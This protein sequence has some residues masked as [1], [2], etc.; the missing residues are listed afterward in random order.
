MSV[1]D[2]IKQKA[3][4]LDFSECGFARAEKVDDRAIERYEQWL[5]TGHNGCMAWA[6]RNIDVRNDPRLLLDGAKTVIMVALNYYPRRFQSPDAAQIAYYAYGRDYHDVI[7]RRLRELAAWISQ[8]TGEKCRALVDSAPLRERYWA[9]KAGLGFIGLNNQLIIPGKG[10][11]FFLGALLTTLELEPDEPCRDSCRQCNRCID[12]CPAKALSGNGAVDAS[13]CL[14]CL[15][16]EN[17]DVLPDWVHNVIGNRVIG[18][19]ECQ[20]C[21]PHNRHATPS[22][23]A[24]FEPDERLLSLSRDEIL[25]LDEQ[26]FSNLFSHSAVRRAGLDTLQRNAKAMN[27]TH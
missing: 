22:T 15:T 9:V 14:S 3:H 5:D 19:D 21:C 24:E 7:K 27:D 12:A 4:E 8:N 10:S 2:D 16:I 23:V 17:H 26:G 13:R 25:A 20:R 6:A 11:Y 1:G 18:C